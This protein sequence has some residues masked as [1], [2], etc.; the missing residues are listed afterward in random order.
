MPSVEGKA[1][2]FEWSRGPA[3]EISQNSI[4]TGSSELM[5]EYASRAFRRCATRPSGLGESHWWSV[6]V[7]AFE[8]AERLR[9]GLVQDRGQRT[10]RS[11]QALN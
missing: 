6:V 2:A 3:S 10:F 1:H 4:L 9:D 7:Q 8:L 5:I 11:V